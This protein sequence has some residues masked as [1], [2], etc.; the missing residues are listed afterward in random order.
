MKKVLWVVENDLQPI[1]DKAKF[2]GAD[3]IC[4][5]TSNDWITTS[6]DTVH[7][8]GLKL[9]G[10]RWPNVRPVPPEQDHLHLYAMNQAEFVKG[11][12]R[13]GLDGYIA[14]IECNQQGDSNC[15]NDPAMKPLAVQFSSAIKTAGRAQNPNFFFG[16][17]SG[18]AF[19]EPTNR[20][21]IP[22]AEFAGASNKL[23]PQSYWIDG[24][25]RILGGTPLK[26]F[27]RSIKAWQ[28]IAP[29]GTP[30]VPML[31]EIETAT[32]DEIAS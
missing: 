10:W 7:Q 27:T 32:A 8:A 19:P 24:S 13:S 12:I 26:A 22:W 29:P 4:A 30:I 20:P 6:I 23:F 1:I 28:R 17:T 11:L 14:D 21:N 5:R 2:I 25:T 15:W 31:G 9:Y 16:L 3:T 18:G